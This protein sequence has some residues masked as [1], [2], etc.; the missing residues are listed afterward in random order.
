MLVFWD[1]MHIKKLAGALSPVNQLLRSSACFWDRMLI[2]HVKKYRLLLNEWK[3][4]I[5]GSENPELICSFNN[6]NIYTLA[7]EG[8]HS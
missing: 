5:Q 2:K 4:F 8:N 3:L 1:R 7:T 6:K